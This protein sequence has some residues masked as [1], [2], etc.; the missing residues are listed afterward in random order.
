MAEMTVDLVAPDRL[1]WSGQ[2]TLVLARTTEGEIGIMPGHE[3]LLGQIFPNPVTIRRPDGEPIIAAV[4]GG[5]LSV[6]EEKV[7]IL[8]E[9]VELASEIDVERARRALERA[10]QG[11]ADDEEAQAAARRAAARLQAG[12][13]PAS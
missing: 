11:A 1:V 10:Q 4:S 7:T 9:A 3:P 13:R 8:G 5:Y 2:A 12:G 6:T